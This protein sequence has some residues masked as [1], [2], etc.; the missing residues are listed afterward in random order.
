[1]SASHT[2]QQGEHLSRIAKSH[3]FDGINPIWDHPQN[4]NLRSLR[5]NPNVL[6]PGDVVFI[7][8]PKRQKVVSLK[9]GQQHKFKVHRVELHLRLVFQDWNLKPI[10]SAKGKIAVG[11]EPREV[12]T[13]GKGQVEL[14]IPVEAEV[15]SIV[16]P[17]LQIELPIRV[18]HLDPPD[19][20]SGMVA[21]LNNLG[22]DAG[23]AEKAGPG[24]KVDE[25][26]LHSAIE[27]F[28][29][30]HGLKVDGVAGPVTRNK[31]RDVHGS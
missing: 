6:A 2:V 30:D 13:D 10:A 19:T 23:L 25:R 11:G 28:Q 21:R 26:R 14:V 16:F 29:C 15:G 24:D 12:T 9:T 31:L 18:G 17:A 22:Y 8:D 1:M 20:P 5:Q 4:S 27:E 3:G 7:P